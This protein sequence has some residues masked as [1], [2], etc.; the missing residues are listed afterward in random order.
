MRWMLRYKSLIRVKA[1]Q[2]IGIAE[3]KILD[4]KGRELN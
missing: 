3:A 2:A 1:D 4:R